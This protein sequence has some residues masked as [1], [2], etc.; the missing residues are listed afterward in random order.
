MEVVKVFAA[1]DANLEAKDKDGRTPI[2]LA[3]ENG[4]MEFLRSVLTPTDY[5]EL[6]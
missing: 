5:F 4:K 2:A 1:L 6:M 3:F